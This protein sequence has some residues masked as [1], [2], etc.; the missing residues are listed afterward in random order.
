MGFNLVQDSGACKKQIK[1]LHRGEDSNPWKSKV[2]K[3]KISLLL[4]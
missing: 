4:V 3:S 1:K 2:K